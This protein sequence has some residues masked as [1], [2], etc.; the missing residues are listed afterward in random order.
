[1]NKYHAFNATEEKNRI[2]KGSNNKVV[3][4]HFGKYGPTKDN[5]FKLIVY[6]THWECR[7]NSFK[8]NGTGHIARDFLQNDEI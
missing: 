6:P 1:M 5:F 2:W 8:C 3:C 7:R 4:Y